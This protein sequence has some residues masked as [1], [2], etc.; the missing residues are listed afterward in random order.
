VLVIRARWILP[1]AERPLLN[2]WCAIDRG[3][4]AAIGRAGAA[5]P[6]RDDA[7]LVDLGEMAVLPALTN[8]HTHLELSW[9]RGRVPR[10]GRFTDW[11]RTMLQTRREQSPPD[12]AIAAS[13]DG[14]IDELRASGTGLV[15]DVSNTLV[16]VAP[17]RQS[18]L[19]GVVF[20]EL[21]RFAAADADA[22]LE[23][24]L[25]AVRRCGPSS[26][27]AV[28]LAPHAPYSVSPRLFQ[29]IRAAQERTPFLPSTVHLAESP[30]E[31]ELL[32]TGEGPW[33][34]LL[35]DL[36]A[37]DPSWTAPRT[38]PA[39]YLDQMKVLTPR[40]LAVHGVQLDETA[41]GRL[42]S[43]GTTL[44]TCPRSN[45]YVGAGD[46]PVEHF[47][48]SGVRVAV[49]TD[50][51]ASNDDLNLFSEMAALRRLAPSVPAS[52]L[53][54]SATINGARALGF[55]SETGTIEPGRNA[56]LIAID[57]PS[58]V[59]DVEGYLVSGITVDTVRWVSEMIADCGLLIDCGLR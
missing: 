51:L 55:E 18:A 33:R 14:A 48:R 23:Q 39:S 49:G 7:P 3:R 10:S 15:G 21:L 4:I 40:L 6:F 27:M 53:L 43:R 56:S 5:L 38:D 22:V 17:L 47:Y 30:E 46:P 57:L 2:G 36:G 42:A 59:V 8:A 12:D 58:N 50:S 1:I 52:L 13:V 32:A 28:S 54:E 37:W 20:H 41:L 34:D 16:T 29:G 45:Q 44:V 11:V 31:I 25:E 26:R 35:Q 24:G 19:S 9:M